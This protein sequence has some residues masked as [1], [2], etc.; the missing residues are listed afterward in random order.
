MVF[1][2]WFN[3]QLKQSFV[4]I[5]HEHKLLALNEL[6]TLHIIYRLSYSNFFETILQLAVVT[7]DRIIKILSSYCY[8]PKLEKDTVKT[9]KISDDEDCVTLRGKNLLNFYIKNGYFCFIDDKG[10]KS[11]AI[12]NMK[13]LDHL[14][15]LSNNIYQIYLVD[16]KQFKALIDLL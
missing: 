2:F 14:D 11:I 6:S 9:I 10:N 13:K 7:N 5:V 15:S 3:N 4:T 8:L 16:N 1:M 12:N